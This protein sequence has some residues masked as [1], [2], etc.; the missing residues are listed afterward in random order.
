MFIQTLH[1]RNGYATLQRLR[2][3]NIYMNSHKTVDSWSV[4]VGKK[5]FCSL[6][7]ILDTRLLVIKMPEMWGFQK[8]WLFSS[9]PRP[10]PRLGAAVGLEENKNNCWNRVISVCVSIHGFNWTYHNSF[11]SFWTW[12]IQNCLLVNILSQIG[13]KFFYKQIRLKSH[14]CSKYA[15]LSF[16]GMK[17]GGWHCTPEQKIGWGKLTSKW[18]RR[19]KCKVKMLFEKK[20]GKENHLSASMSER[21]VLHRWS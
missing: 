21:K 9:F 4:S 15:R 3:T 2:M 7:L 20:R 5:H 11:K 19:G 10:E 1:V 17:G 12:W 8:N 14:V 6:L 13:W 18:V 16:P